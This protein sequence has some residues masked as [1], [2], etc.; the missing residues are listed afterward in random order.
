MFFVSDFVVRLRQKTQLKTYP[1]QRQGLVPRGLFPICEVLILFSVSNSDVKLRL[2]AQLKT[3]LRK[4]QGLVPRS[5]FRS[6]NFSVPSL[7]LIEF[8]VVH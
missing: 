3:Y 6:F 2:K 5:L 7:A 1:R 8:V 4:R